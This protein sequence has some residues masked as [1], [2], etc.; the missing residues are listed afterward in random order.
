M[1]WEQSYQQLLSAPYALHLKFTIHHLPFIISFLPPN[2]GGSN[3]GSL[4]NWAEYGVPPKIGGQGGWLSS[5][6]IILYRAD[7]PH[8]IE[9][10]NI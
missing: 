6:K 5:Y 1:H 2:P 7:H 3:T 10:H 4:Q 8:D 9:L